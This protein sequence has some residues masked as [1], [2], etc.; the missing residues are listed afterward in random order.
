MLAAH[1]V[2]NTVS[3]HKTSHYSRA[4]F[5]AQHGSHNVQEG[6][7]AQIQQPRLLQT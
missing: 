5:F 4:V 6:R 7:R 2:V 1:V 3:P